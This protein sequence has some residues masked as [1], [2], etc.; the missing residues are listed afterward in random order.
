MV[1]VIGPWCIASFV[2]Y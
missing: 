1:L 2:T